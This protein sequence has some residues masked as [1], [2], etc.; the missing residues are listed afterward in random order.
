MPF[1]YFLALNIRPQ[2]L[3]HCL[4]VLFL[5]LKPKEDLYLNTA[6]SHRPFFRFACCMMAIYFFNILLIG[7]LIAFGFDAYQAGAI[8]LIPVTLVSYF[9]QKLIVFRQKKIL[10]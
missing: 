1:C 6:T 2:I 10:V 4:P 9:A 3:E 7:K 5:A 8:A